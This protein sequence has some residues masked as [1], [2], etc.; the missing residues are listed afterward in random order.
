[1]SSVLIT[2]LLEAAFEAVLF[3]FFFFGL[4]KASRRRS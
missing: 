4:Q 3:G 2:I 1:M